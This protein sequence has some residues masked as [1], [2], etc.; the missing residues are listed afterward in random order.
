MKNFKI[1]Q[2]SDFK[3]AAN[4]LSL[5]KSG[6]YPMAGGTDILD[7]IKNG[8]ISPEAVVDLTSIP[9]MS[10]IQ[11]D[12]NSLRIGALTPVN[13]LIE[14]RLIE[15]DYPVLHQAALSLATPQLRN[16]GTVGGNLCQHPR[17]WYYRDPQILCW[18]KGGDD[19]FA[20]AGKNKYHAI[21][22]GE[23]CFIVHPSDLAPALI[24]L[25]AE[26]L[27]AT[28][29][30]EKKLKLADFYHL[31]QEN[32]R[33]E[34]ILE[35]GELVKEILLPLPKKEEK[36]I[37][38]KIKERNTWDFAVV[39]AAV[40]VKFAGKKIDDIRIVLGGVA[41]IPWRLDKTEKQLKG[42]NATE[43]SIRT[44]AQEGLR[45]AASLEENGYKLDLVEAVLVETIT[46]LIQ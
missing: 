3:Q 37:Y 12:K 28:P 21:F 6:F 31:P 39:S 8:I 25:D 24:C 10:F 26:V 27:I 11:Q 32:R 1:A 5:K 17:C 13:D 36:S 18:K 20:Y 15:S 29:E 44:A 38:L 22:G 46:S 41:P 42:K 45:D 14:S 34:T 40:K 30:K 43:K 16:I 7:E 4:L 35:E 19:C 9:N 33:G 2:P 23:F